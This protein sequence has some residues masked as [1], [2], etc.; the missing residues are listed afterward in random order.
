MSLTV[1]EDPRVTASAADL[2]QLLDFQHA[3]QASLAQAYVGTGQVQAVAAQLAALQARSTIEAPLRASI[4]ALVA[5]LQP[6]GADAAGIAAFEH[7]SGELAALATDAGSA[8]AAPT[9][10][11]RQVLSAAATRVD[12][13]QRRWQALQAGPLAALNARLVQ[14]GLAAIRVPMPDQVQ[15]QPV[16][17]GQDRP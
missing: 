15:V 4:T 14:A 13:A 17:E 2:A 10:A 7:A 11:Q 5:Q 9:A 12:A 1:T 6:A 16:P 8:D 3:V